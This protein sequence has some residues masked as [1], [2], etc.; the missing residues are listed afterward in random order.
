MKK[1]GLILSIVSAVCAVMTYV[2]L[3]FNF[4]VIT[5]SV[6][7]R[8]TSNSGSFADWQKLLGNDMEKLGLWKFSRV[9]MILALILVAVVAI[10]AIVNVFVN[11]KVL[12]LVNRIVSIVGLV[13]TVAFL[14]TFVAGGLALSDS[15]TLLNVTTTVAYLPNA[16]PILL[17]LFGIAAT[18]TALL[19]T[20]KKKKASK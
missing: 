15:S 19:T 1:K 13:I 7:N 16:G 8:S 2:A 20:L 4:V 9:L 5:T 11:N 12:N 17:S 18:V 14:V 6:G 10:L 3:A